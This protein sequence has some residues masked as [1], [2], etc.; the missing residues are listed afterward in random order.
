M[1]APIKAVLQCLG[2]WRTAA[3][4]VVVAKKDR[5]SVDVLV[6]RAG[7][8]GLPARVDRR[9]P[10]RVGRAGWDR[11]RLP[12]HRRPAVRIDLWG[13]E[14]DRLTRFDVADQRSIDDL[15]RV[16]LF[17]CREL[18]PD[19]AMRKQAAGLVGSAPWGRH[20]W[21]RLADGDQFDGM[22]S[23]LPWLVDSEELITDLLGDGALVVLVEPRRMRDRA[24]ELVDEESALADA[25]AT[26]WGL[27][28]GR[29]APRLHVP[30]DRLL[31]DTGAAWSRWSPRPTD[32]T[33]PRSRAGGGSRS[34]GT[35]PS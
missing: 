4:P 5:V 9:T 12:L 21:D 29:R 16:E 17:G 27:E 25:L 18:V 19:E 6:D 34:W 11:R 26:T 33:S 3:R 8:H 22:E 24:A 10:G 28:A 13:D 2:P 35:R 20:Q 23:W 1:V 14:V 15:D 32:R 31:A 7:G 30:F